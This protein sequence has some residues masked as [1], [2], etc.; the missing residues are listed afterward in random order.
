MKLIFIIY[1]ITS[2]LDVYGVPCNDVPT[3]YCLMIDEFEESMEIFASLSK[4][5]PNK[6]NKN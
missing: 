2:V 3:G 6:I 1:V 4:R 5:F